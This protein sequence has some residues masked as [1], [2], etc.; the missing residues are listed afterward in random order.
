MNNDCDGLICPE[1]KIKGEEKKA[2]NREGPQR[3]N[4][5]RSY[6]TTPWTPFL[7]V[8]ID[9][10]WISENEWKPPR[11]NGETMRKKGLLN[12]LFCRGSVLRKS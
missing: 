4:S 6:S 9:S 11:S 8:L 10:L 12:L 3:G 7:T 1:K 5:L 2:V